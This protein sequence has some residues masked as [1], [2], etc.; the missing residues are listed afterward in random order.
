MQ[1]IDTPQGRRYSRFMF[2]KALKLLVNLA[3]SRDFVRFERLPVAPSKLVRSRGNAQS[4]KGWNR[5]DQ[6]ARIENLLSG[7]PGT[8]GRNS[9]RGK[10]PK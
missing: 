5:H 3:M 1:M 4:I 8:V 7:R 9:D 10:P 2:V 6:F